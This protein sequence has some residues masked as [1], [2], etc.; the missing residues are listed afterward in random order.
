[1]FIVQH[2]LDVTKFKVKTAVMK[3][4]H[5]HPGCDLGR[6]L[7][8]MSNPTDVI[9]A[10]ASGGGLHSLNAFWFCFFIALYI[11]IV[12]YSFLYQFVLKRIY[13]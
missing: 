5:L 10:T 1:M 3:I 8:Q 6:Y 9:L 13:Q 11:V 2:T 4:I 12:L 7:H